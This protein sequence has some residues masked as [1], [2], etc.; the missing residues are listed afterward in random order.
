M[1]NP[2]IIIVTIVMVLLVF[3]LYKEWFHPAVSFIIAVT[4]LHFTGVLG[5]DDVLK[6]FANR[7][8]AVI[9]ML[10]VLADIMRKMQVVDVLFQKLLRMNLSYRG[11]LSSMIL[12]TGSLSAFINNTPLVAILI[13]Y[14]SD[15]AK[16]NGITPSK[17][18]IP[19]SYATIL[20]GTLTLI[21]TSTNM[22]VNSLAMASG[23]PSLQM[24]DFT[25]VG[26]PLMISGML[27][28][29]FWLSRKLPERKDVISNL[30]EHTREYMVEAT[31]RPK[32]WYVGK[33]VSEASLRQ[34]RGLYLVEIIRNDRVLTPV[35]PDEILTADDIL[36]F[37]GD[38]ETIM[39]LMKTP[40]DLLIHDASSFVSD[41]NSELVEAVVPHNS[42]LIQTSLKETDF[43]ARYNASI[44]AVHRNGEK[45][46]GK[47]GDINLKP[48]DMLLLIAGKDF[49]IRSEYSRDLYF[50]NKLR[51]VDKKNVAG[52]AFV[53]LGTVAA[54][55]LS[56]F[57][58]FHLFQSLMVLLTLC[59][60][61]RLIK[62]GDLQKSIDF[63][64]VLI[65]VSALALSIAMQ[66]SGTADLIGN[67]FLNLAG[68][69]SSGYLSASILALIAI[70]IV[71][72]FLT[73]IITN[74]A[75]A[76]IILPIALAVAL[77]LGLDPKPF[78]LVVAFAGSA[79]FAT[80]F[81]Y[82]TN[83]MVYGPGGYRFSDFLRVGIPLN[84]MAAIVTV[85]MLGYLY[86]L[87]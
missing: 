3:T 60:V 56:V 48:G 74:A 59:V 77:Q 87:F 26:I 14:V 46:S 49:T 19:L 37:A 31:V 10:I 79:S 68:L 15:W 86:R 80:P 63:G 7:E 45:L 66:Q 85:A 16:K 76:S 39:D 84:I 32:S 75:A 73:E 82:Q 52:A 70:Y 69:L 6:G 51:E 41:G 67:A 62:P 25:P 38:T 64:L 36:I 4:L 21:G 22:V 54:I 42:P 2:Q 18:L 78:I 34:L 55:L 24:F 43:R 9:I 17:L 40:G 71:T 50:V 33:K 83:L 65:L 13:P 12:S 23:Q 28:I 61:F 11:F 47:I 27:F 8:V 20:G 29:T 53:V 58:V 57:H 5:M 44:I 1:I 81:G 72:S 35:S 30:S